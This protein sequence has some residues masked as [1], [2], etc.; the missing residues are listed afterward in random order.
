MNEKKIFE[1]L[2]NL[3][4]DLAEKEINKL[5]EGVE[6]DMAS[7]NK[8]AHQKLNDSN[9]KGKRRKMLPYIAVVSIG[10]LGVTSAYAGDISETIKSFFNK[11]PIYSTIVD[12]DAYYLKERYALNDKITI[13]S[14]MVSEGNLEMEITSDIDLSKLDEINIIPQNDP[15]TV[16]YPGGYSGE[17]K[18]F[19][20]SFMN[21]TENNYNIKP[22]KD[23]KLVIGGDSYD[24]S[25][26]KAESLDL[27]SKI[28]TSSAG[29]SN[30]KGVNIG[31][32]VIDENGKAN[33][34]I[35]TSFEDKNLKLTSLGKPMESKVISTFEDLGKDG[36]I[37][38]ST[39]SFCEP[40][41]VFDETNAK[42]K[43]EIPENS[44]GRPVT[45]FE[46]N[47]PIGKNL[48][49]KV[50]AL[51]ASIEKKIVSIPLSIPN[52]GEVE[53]N[54]GID[55]TVQKAVVKNI[56]RLSATSAQIEF[57]LNTG[58]NKNIDIRSF[59]LDS[60]DIKKMSAE[61]NDSK[62]I[63]TLEFNK[64]I[65]EITIELSYPEFV[66]NGNWSINLHEK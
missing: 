44:K 47:A 14:I 16:Y 29:K 49:L 24:A 11:T 1:L 5:L 6:I 40:F 60:P 32:K 66:M 64:S 39:S 63:M 62:A 53:V 12:G 8:K 65:D 50:P 28:Y 45:T 58:A 56:K 25:L 4:D 34:Q 37:G 18:K 59:D 41:Y 43:L 10:L 38:S 21:K 33:I 48:S 55:F 20:F 57:E 52:E 61:F 7:I 46:T 2:N 30:I 35:I 22:F 23:F 17:G 19:F 42:Y 27:N 3:D 26:E 13:E 54:K 31:A 15:T 9:K 51:V 36:M